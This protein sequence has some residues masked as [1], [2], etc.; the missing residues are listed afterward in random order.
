MDADEALE[1]RELTQAVIGIFYS[2]YNE[3]GPGF[4]ESIYENA[5]AIALRDAGFEARQ[6]H[7]LQVWF[8]GCVVGEFKVDLLVRGTLVIELKAVSQ[9]LPIHEVQLVNYLKGLHMHVGLLFNFG[10]KPQ[11]KRRVHGYHPDDPRS[12]ALIRV[13]S[14]V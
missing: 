7:P 1:D 3:L 13:Q 9:I 11:F 14:H 2:V 12:S 6:Q 5:M 8:R 10:P 4:L